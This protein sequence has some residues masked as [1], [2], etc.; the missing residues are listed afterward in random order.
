MDRRKFLAYV[1][2][3]APTLTVAGR[4]VVGASS[5]ALA[6]VPEVIPGPTFS[7]YY[8]LGDALVQASAPTMP[9]LT[10]EI[11]PE[12]IA[13]FRLPRMEV[14]Q[15]ITTTVAMLIAEE[16][17]TDEAEWPIENVVVTLEDARPD[18]VYNQ[19]TGGS[20][21]VRALYQPV[22]R[23]AAAAREAMA[24]NA[25][26]GLTTP[27][28]D[29]L[30]GGS[31]SQLTAAL[32]RP[33]DPE[34]RPIGEHKVLGR[35]QT[36]IDAADIVTGRP[37][38][39]LDIA[40]EVLPDAIA[41]VAVHSPRIRSTLLAFNNEDAI[42][43]MP[44]V[45]DVATIRSVPNAGYGE[46][47]EWGILG[48]LT[49]A[50]TAIVIGAETFGH[51]LA[52]AEQVDADWGPGSVADMS[53]EDFWTDLR[54]NAQPTTAGVPGD[55]LDSEFEFA[56]VAHAPMETMNALANV[57]ADGAEVW[58]GLKIP[59]P[60]QEE[61]AQA[62]GLPISA[63]TV[64]VVQSGGSF[65]R[66]LFHETATEAA[67]A[68][69]AFG[70][71]VKLMWSRP[72]DMRNDRL[73]PATYHN[74]RATLQGDTIAAFEHR[75]TGGSTNF[76][77][78]LGDALSS[79]GAHDP[80]TQE[81][82]FLSIF[83]T[84]M[85]MPYDL[86]AVTQAAREVDYDMLTGSW[87]SVYTGTGRTVEEIVLDEIAARQGRDPVELRLA[88][89]KSDR[90]RA[91]LEKVAEMG[92]WGATLPEGVAQGVAANTE[93]RSHMACLVE[94]DARGERPRVTKA[95]MAFDAGIPL[96]PSGLEAQMYGGLNDA[97]ATILQAGIHI[98]AGA[99]R[100]STFSDFYYTR[101]ADYP[102][103]V[104]VH[105]MPKIE[106]V[107]P[108]GAGEGMVPTCAGAIANALNRATG[109]VHRRFPIN[110]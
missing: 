46:D 53:S 90:T 68:S 63:V 27:P 41:T 25:L 93:H 89:L 31:V 95:Y 16:L 77:H 9:L 107:E 45:I 104:E 23:M 6:Q 79:V 102:R 58:S 2:T 75:F 4:W 69:A 54:A 80:A 73:R 35:R 83:N 26:G 67:L 105:V 64:H 34:P 60:A 47:L 51:A 62:L 40:D 3:T 22:S 71:P 101:M 33:G 32:S 85:T 66:R 30:P 24:G 92:G 19:L 74:I 87:R 78:G 8:D 7:D 61:I 14:G 96:N 55:A 57:T 17:S 97:I 18:L 88:V 50:P 1:V 82:V 37:R 39:T 99:I 81:G 49:G 106:G 5:P 52:A 44:G 28:R 110:F 108:G 65:G 38:Y 43:A 21:N 72:E 20:Y 56:H 11:T 10:L 70:R 15:G 76:S 59:V 42:R 12:G 48:E 100:E 94:L 29:P 109:T 13:T 103:V 84:Q 98:D 36:R 86:G 91:V